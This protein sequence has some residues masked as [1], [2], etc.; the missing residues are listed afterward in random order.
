MAYE[1]Y[2]NK[3]A[4]TNAAE[5]PDTSMGMASNPQVDTGISKR[6]AIG[7]GLAAMRIA[8][9]AKQVFN[10]VLNST[11]DNSTKRNINVATSI[12]G[13][14]LMSAQLGLPIAIG[15]EAVS[16]TANAISRAIEQRDANINQA[17]DMQKQGV[18][19]NHF[20]GTGAYYD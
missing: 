20:L 9:A 3:Q 17:Y 13:F 14:G 12:M 6:Q 8:P 15:V 11:G 7:T 18:A 19:F 16:I 1:V 10:T 5:S 2:Y 4:P